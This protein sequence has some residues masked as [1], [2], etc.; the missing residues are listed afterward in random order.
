M[1]DNLAIAIT[2]LSAHALGL[3]VFSLGGLSDATYA[4]FVLTKG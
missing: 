3:S 1:K 4:V 2:F